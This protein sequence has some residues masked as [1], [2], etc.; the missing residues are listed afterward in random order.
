MAR[1]GD[2]EIFKPSGHKFLDTRAAVKYMRNIQIQTHPSLNVNKPVLLQ[3]KDDKKL[4]PL[5]EE[6]QQTPPPQTPPPHVRIVEDIWDRVQTKQHDRLFDVMQKYLDSSY[7]LPSI[8]II[9]SSYI[10][11]KLNANC[12]K[13]QQYVEQYNEKDPETTKR[14]A[15]FIDG[16][17]ITLHH[18]DLIQDYINGIFSHHALKPHT[19]R[20]FAE[21][22]LFIPIILNLQNI[23]PQNM[24]QNIITNKQLHVKKN[25]RL[26][27][28]CVINANINKEKKEKIIQKIIHM[29]TIEFTENDRLE[30]V[31][32][33]LDDKL[34]DERK[35]H[36][37]K[38][39]LE[40]V[41]I[42]KPKPDK[43]IRQRIKKPKKE[44]PQPASSQVDAPIIVPNVQKQPD[45]TQ[46]ITQPDDDE[47]KLGIDDDVFTDFWFETKSGDD[48][49]FHLTPSDFINTAYNETAQLLQYL[50]DQTPQFNEIFTN[51]EEFW[52]DV[53]NRAQKIYNNNQI[54]K[55]KEKQKE[56]KKE[57]INAIEKVNGDKKIEQKSNTPPLSEI[58][59]N[60]IDDQDA[61]TTKVDIKPTSPKVDIKPPIDQTTTTNIFETIKRYLMLNTILL[62]LLLFNVISSII[63]LIYYNQQ[64]KQQYAEQPNL[65]IKSAL[66]PLQQYKKNNR[67]MQKILAIMILSNILSI[68]CSLFLIVF[69]QKY[70]KIIPIVVMITNIIHLLLHLNYYYIHVVI[71]E[72]LQSI[73]IV[74]ICISLLLFIIEFLKI[75]KQ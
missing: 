19:V 66:Y 16:S 3:K 67:F 30:P 29:T 15:I 42:I 2:S 41:P 24:N 56:M 22:N 70:N 55:P 9:G 6:P 33:Y 4:S 25:S 43:K 60:I 63:F 5:D 52:T 32:I 57:I 34:Y 31:L 13:L 62:I 40:Q 61:T 35:K 37:K 47:K 71:I 38:S 7:E 1:A 26:I 51:N 14:L 74:Y 44:K 18:G 27:A 12:T 45:S 39:I 73:N 20:I 72:D 69:E 46:L 23:P 68:I 21:V 8:I 17:R 49:F 11:N 59:Q 48:D 53:F 65:S 10:I 50:Y 28:T 64:L 36:K 54:N 58:K 75:M